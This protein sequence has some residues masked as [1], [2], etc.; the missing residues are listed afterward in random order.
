MKA[1]VDTARDYF[2]KCISIHSSL[3]PSDFQLTYKE[4]MF[5]VECCVYNY[6]GNDLTDIQALGELFLKKKFFKRK[7]DVSIYK[8]KLGV[9]RWAKTGRKEFILPPMLAKKEGDKLSSTI[10]IEYAKA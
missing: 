7:E 3:M 2:Y 5:L 6:E 10:V 8:Y 4:T 1:Q 9:K